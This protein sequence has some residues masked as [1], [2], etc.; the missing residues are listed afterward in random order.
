M[1]LATPRFW[2]RRRRGWQTWLL[3]PLAWL[4]GKAVTLHRRSTRRWHCAVPVLSI[5]NLT[6]G[7]TGKTPLGIALAKGLGERGWRVAVLLRGYGTRSSHSCPLPTSRCMLWHSILTVGWAVA[8]VRSLHTL[9]RSIGSATIDRP[10]S[11]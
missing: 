11:E 1:P 10:L 2:Y 6:L 4:Y 7:G 5:G 9:C 3:W 8:Q